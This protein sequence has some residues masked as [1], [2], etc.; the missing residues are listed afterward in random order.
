M[1]R[2][3]TVYIILIL[4]LFS[5]RSFAG[6]IHDAAKAGD[7][8]K[9]EKLL[10]K[11]SMFSGPRDVNEQNIDKQTPLHIAGQNG[12]TEIVKL[13]I[14][15][16][17]SIEAQNKRNCTP[18]H[19]AAHSGHIESVKQ[20]ISVGANIEAG[21]SFMW[22]PLH[23]AAESG[24]ITVVKLLIS[25]GAK[26]NA[27]DTQKN[28]PL[29]VATSNINFKIAKLLISLGANL[30]A[31]NEDGNTPSEVLQLSTPM[32]EL[33]AKK[34][35]ALVKMFYMA[36]RGQLIE[37][38]GQTKAPSTPNIKLTP[39]QQKK[40]DINLLNAAKSGDFPT[41]KRSINAGADIE[42]RNGC[43]GTPLLES[44]T[45]GHTKIVEF[46]ITEGAFIEAQMIYGK[47]T[48]LQIASQQ[49]H[50]KIVK[51]LLSAGAEVDHNLNRDKYTPLHYAANGGHTQIAKLLIATNADKEAR[52]SYH[53]HTPLHTAVM[54]GH[55]ETVKLLVSSGANIDS[56]ANDNS[57][58]LHVSAEYGHHE[59]AK[60]LI[61][62]K[63]NLEA[64]TVYDDY[65]PLHLAARWGCVEVVKLLI[66]AGV[67]TTSKT[68]SGHTALT[69]VQSDPAGSGTNHPQIIT[70][71]QKAATTN[72]S[73]TPMSTTKLTTT[74]P[75]PQEHWKSFCSPEYAEKR[76]LEDCKNGKL[77][78]LNFLISRAT[79]G[80]GITDSDHNTPL[81][82][83]AHNGHPK[84]AK[85]L[86]S[87]GAPI[88]AGSKYGDTPLHLAGYLGHTE[89]VKI[90][91]ANNADISIKNTYGRTALDRAR[92]K[93]R[94]EII[95]LLESS[96]PQITP[97]IPSKKPIP[98]ITQSKGT[99]F[100]IK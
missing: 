92:E 63:A 41:T 67:D 66:D 56:E 5:S 3:H 81:H 23:F 97:S 84:V 25:A 19:L 62:A 74:K 16:G 55:A 24:H 76:L 53:E 73:T 7:L 50:L 69:V 71:L 26:I 2:H 68:R 89:V 8:V 54:K 30:N 85:F 40:L 10:T 31:L 88:N 1:N 75:H 60:L 72:A 83:A 70:L 94:T 96:K 4:G 44:S 22:A 80:V 45:Y 36:K 77:I 61:S 14:S 38:V 59:S 34:H 18:L 12:H 58:P 100:S 90:L 95:K 78:D 49:G 65:T 15:R 29:H 82:W 42:A 48:S 20:L 35:S 32:T 37:W 99:D 57:T 11:G 9:V 51:L 46:L 86:L 93:N 98:T 64:R 17:A 52:E 6:K 28:T 33:V 47:M 27:Q 21:A 87:N 91:L 79:K 39:D 13:L 43:G